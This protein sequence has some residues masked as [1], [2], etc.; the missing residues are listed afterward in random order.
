MFREQLIKELVKSTIEWLD[1]LD[2]K[3]PDEADEEDILLGL[4]SYVMEWSPELDM[5]CKDL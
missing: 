1:Y 2:Y 3:S 4:R 5:S